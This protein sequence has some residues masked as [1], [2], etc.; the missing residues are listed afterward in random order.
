MDHIN[1]DEEMQVYRVVENKESM[2]MDKRVLMT[3]KMPTSTSKYVHNP[4][5]HV[6]QSMTSRSETEN[7]KC[8]ESYIA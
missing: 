7:L 1:K 3:V 6:V 8:G 5:I 4:N 2:N